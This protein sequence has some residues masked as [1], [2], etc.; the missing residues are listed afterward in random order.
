MKAYTALC[1]GNQEMAK[2]CLATVHE[3]LVA[4]GLLASREDA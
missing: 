1:N 3:G 4:K 2:A